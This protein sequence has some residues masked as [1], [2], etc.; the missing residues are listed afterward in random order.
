MEFGTG[1]LTIT[2]NTRSI[3]HYSATWLP[4]EDQ[5]AL[6]LRKKTT[7]MFGVKIGKGIAWIYS[8]PFRMARKI[9]SIGLR[10]T[11]SLLVDRIAKRN[12]K[13]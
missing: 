12:Q 5:K 2:L 10:K 7:E 13:N 9:K 8:L 6:R 11:L 1:K 3:H 4:K